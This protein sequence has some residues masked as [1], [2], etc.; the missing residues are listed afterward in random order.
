VLMDDAGGDAFTGL[1]DADD[2]VE[3]VQVS[4]PGWPRLSSGGQVVSG[5]VTV[6]VGL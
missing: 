2:R 5:G 1:G 3:G 4:N 6:G